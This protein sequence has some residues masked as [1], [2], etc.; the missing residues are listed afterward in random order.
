MEATRSDRWIALLGPVFLVLMVLVLVLGGNTPAEN[1]SGQ[2]L[3][4]HYDGKAGANL[5]A[6]FLVGPAVVA[7]LLFVGWF[8]LLLG[9][10]IGA[11]RKLLQYGAVVYGVAL[12]MIAAVNLAEVGAADDKQAGAAQAMNYLNNAMWIPIVIGAGALLIGAGWA[13]LRSGILPGW[14]GWIA[15]VVGII[16][17]L[18]PGGFAGFFL[19]PLWVAAAGLMLYLRAPSGDPVAVG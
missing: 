7:L 12:L 15:L 4:A 9:R 13:V 10:D 1:S 19:G 6:A 3:I 17:L 2:K 8:R 16:S 14:L 11:P 18:G 5:A